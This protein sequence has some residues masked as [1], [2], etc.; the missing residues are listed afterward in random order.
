M[1]QLC[2]WLHCNV[3]SKAGESFCWITFLTYMLA[4]YLHAQMLL[5]QG[6]IVDGN[7]YKNNI[8]ILSCRTTGYQLIDV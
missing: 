8:V 4:F 3:E 6:N 2:N 7:A 1:P 5:V